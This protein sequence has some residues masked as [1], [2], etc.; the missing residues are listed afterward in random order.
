MATRCN[1]I[2]KFGKSTVH[3]YRHWDGYPAVCGAAIV[4]A[5]NATRKAHNPGPAFVS[6]LLA[7]RNE[8]RTGQTEG[9]P[10]YEL[11]DDL[12]G[13]I[14]HVYAVR[15]NASDV[16]KI[17]H[18]ARPQGMFDDAEGWTNDGKPLP[19]SGFVAIVNQEREEMNMRLVELA[20]ESAFYADA[21]PFALVALA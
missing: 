19:M 10:I 7:L 9:S 2:V 11:T 17:R 3:L 8:P 12:H 4:E 13:D 18:A 15:F 16:A 6:A 20:K 1:V 14:E 5:Y 21:E